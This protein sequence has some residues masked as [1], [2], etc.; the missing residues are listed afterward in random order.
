MP[1]EQVIALIGALGGAAGFWKYLTVRAEKE[2]ESLMLDKEQRA[3]F[4]STLR[5][6]VES[7]MAKVDKLVEEKEELL[8]AMMEIK[9][10]LAEARTT[11]KH[12]EDIIRMREYSVPNMNQQR[13]DSD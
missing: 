10:E 1:I 12:L 9:A 8:E 2:N 5:T 3:E 11:V 7:L 6:Q 4:N 13:R